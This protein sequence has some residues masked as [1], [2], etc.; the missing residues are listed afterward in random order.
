[1]KYAAIILLLFFV[2]IQGCYYDNKDILNPGGQACD[3]AI[4]TY[5]GAVNPLLTAYCTGCHSGANAPLGV[6]LDTYNGTKSQVS[7][8]KLLGTINHS[9]GFIPMP[10]NDNKLNDCNIAKIRKWITNGALNN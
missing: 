10:K 3:T 9:P 1:M 6:R 5:S 4:V 2:I 8:G 7:N